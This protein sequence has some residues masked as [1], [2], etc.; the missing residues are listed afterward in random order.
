M[1]FRLTPQETSF[2]S[3][4]ATSASLLVDA[5]RELTNILEAGPENRQ[6]I[7]E[8]VRD[9]EHEAD[10]ATHEIIRKTNSS[11]IT[12]FDR[13]DIHALAANLDDC[14][15]HL[16]HA[17]DLIGLYGL[18]ELPEGMAEQFGIL[19]RM[20]EVTAEAMPRLRS[21]KDLASYW[22]EVNRLENQS[23]TLHRR[24]LADLF[25]R[26]T[27]PIHVMK[28]KEVIDGFED[29][30]DSF[31]KVAHTVEGIALKES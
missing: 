4:F 23:D 30:A 31:E 28:V 24:M 8:R 11:F 15:D 22:I 17:T 20:A 25:N 10:E 16:E 26:A 2:Y 1:G 14:M 27:D 3:L 19:S 13:E 29:A 21:F 9:L 5:T 18:D 12:P 7:V 6:R